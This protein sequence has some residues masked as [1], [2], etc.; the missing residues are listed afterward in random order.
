VLAELLDDCLRM[1]SPLAEARGVQIALS[2]ADGVV[3]RADRTR[4]RQVLLN[5]LSN[6]VK[7]NHLQ[8]SVAI[9]AALLGDERVRISVTDTGPGIAEERLA[10]LFEPFD[11]LGAEFG[12]VEGTGVGLTIARQLVELMDGEIGVDGGAGQGACFWIQLP[13]ARLAAPPAV[14][15]AGQVVPL[16]G[17]APAPKCT[18]LYVEDNPA[19]LRLIE[20]VA[21][22]H[23]NLRMLSAPAAAAGLALA[24]SARPDLILLDIHLPDVDGYAVL[25]QLQAD[26]ATRQI[27][28]VAVTAQATP[29]DE[30]RARAAGFADCI[31]KPV[32]IARL[33]ALF[34]GLRRAD[35]PG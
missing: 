31:T 4:L 15:V 35:R 19:S 7:Y 21:S 14:T 25:A 32:D 5:L 8:G 12:E 6:A 33:D 16:Q 24:R 23:A 9:D 11:R 2:G 20:Q 22:R 1:I 13:S 34:Q 18:V 26:A 10:K 29:D 3:L 17:A 27:P 28:V 30:R